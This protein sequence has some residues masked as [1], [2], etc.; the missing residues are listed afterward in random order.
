M[1]IDRTP[2]AAVVTGRP[3]GRKKEQI[4]PPMAEIGP[5]NRADGSAR[6]A[7]VCS[8]SGCDG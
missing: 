5:L 7:Q 6:F 2:I 3:D 4:R 1:E 8:L